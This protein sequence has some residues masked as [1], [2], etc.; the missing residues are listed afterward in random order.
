[1]EGTRFL[2]DHLEL[3]YPT[4]LDSES[5]MGVKE[6]ATLFNLLYFGKGMGFFVAA[7]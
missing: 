7:A 2:C 4:D 5:S 3:S 1:M 6:N